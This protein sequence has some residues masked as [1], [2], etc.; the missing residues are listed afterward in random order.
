MSFCYYL[1]NCIYSL[2][3]GLET[4]VLGVG[5]LESAREIM[6]CTFKILSWKGYVSMRRTEN[7]SNCC[8]RHELLSTMVHKNHT[9][10]ASISF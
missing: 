6:L 4:G 8:V 10:T 2:C 9:L 7:V 3:A 5:G 1:C